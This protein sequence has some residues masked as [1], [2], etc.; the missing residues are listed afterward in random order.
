MR[1][2]PRA[3]L[4]PAA[5]V[6]FLAAGLIVRAIAGPEAGG[7]VMLL[8]LV[9]TGAP[10]VWR[11][12][13]GMLHGR[14]AADLVATLAIVTAAL[15]A[16]PLPG[17]VIVLM[18]TGGEALERFAERRATRAVQEL[19]ARA[20]TIAHRLDPEPH[21]IPVDAIRVGDRLVV[22]P[23]EV[24]PC[25][26]I[27]REGHS[28]VDTAAITGEP[29]P[30][31]ARPG[32]RLLSGTRN[33]DEAA[34]VLEA[35]AV[36]G[37]SQY[38]RIVELVRSAQASKSPF[39]R[40]A[41][42]YAV[43]FTPLTLTACVL[44][45]AVSGEW[46]RVLAVLV[47]A[48]PCPLILAVPVAIIGGINQGARQRLI[49]RN[50]T[51]LERLGTITA[52]AFDKTGTLTGGEPK[53][54]GVQPADHFGKTDILRLAAGVELGSSHV[55]AAPVVAAAREAGAPVALAQGIRE[56][57]GEGVRGRAEGRVV[58]VGSPSFI[59]EHHPDPARRLDA[60]A[61]GDTHTCAYVVVD[62][63]PAA[64]LEYGDILRPGIPALLADLRGLGVRRLLLV[65]GDHAAAVDEVARTLGFTEAHGDLLPAA[66]VDVIRRLRG[67]GERVAMVGDG[68]N[69]APALGAA[70]VGVA[71]AAGGGGIAAETADLVLLGD[72]PR[73]LGPA[74][75]LSRY[76]MRIARQSVGIGMG[77][78][79]SAM[80]LAAAG[81]IAP[82]PG[83]LL[84][85]GIDLLVIM[86][87]LRASGAA[88]ADSSSFLATGFTD[89]R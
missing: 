48:T 66:K 88:P 3:A 65:S 57:P 34:L 14:F 47:V 74:I 63:G 32:T 55:M 18:Q 80:V 21:D 87:A 36:A 61:S 11:T 37:E 12:L 52:A 31:A 56:W 33:S 41:D 49:F 82:T 43:W 6:T 67:E 69:D 45:W 16:M 60:L 17:L 20:P 75:R 51:A 68:T 62:G 84:Q 27:V 73:L 53:I 64:V 22:R 2:V 7:R 28:W 26:G 30:L 86:N 81:I 19:E 50:G 77:L 4:P 1:S 78:S 83:A 46:S 89:L 59:R 5:V 10:V 70:D 23:G 44:A 58:W 38:A 71:L 54:V 35:T 40:L 9:L 76:T 72:D 8:G 42:R 25:D 13:R 29:L 39:Q 85:E 79:L 15:L 24:I